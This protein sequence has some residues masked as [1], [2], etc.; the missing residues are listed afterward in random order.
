MTLWVSLVGEIAV[1]FID[2]GGPRGGFLL[3]PSV[4]IVLKQLIRIK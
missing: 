4:D 2:D 1:S 3:L